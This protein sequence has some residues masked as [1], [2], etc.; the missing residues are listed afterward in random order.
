MKKVGLVSL[1]CAKNLI[2]SEMILG[3]LD[4]NKYILTN[5]PKEADYI[6]IN[7]CAFIE[8]SKKETIET[9][10]EMLTYQNA[11]IIV[12]GCMAQR[13]KEILQKEIPEISLFITLDD[14]PVFNEKLSELDDELHSKEG[15]DFRNRLLSTKPFT[16]YLRIADGCNNCCSYCAIPLIRGNLKSREMDEIILEAKDLAFKGVKE[17]V[18]IAQDTTRY[19]DDL[20]SGANIEKLLK[21][22][23]KIEDFAY[24]RLLYLYP[25][26]ITDELIELI[27]SEKKLTPYFDIPIQHSEN[28]VLRNMNRR[29]DKKFLLE[30]FGKIKARVPN[31]ILRTTIMVG[32]PGESETDFANLLEFVKEVEF[33]HLGAFTYS[34]EEDTAAHSFSNQIEEGVKKE[35]IDK[36]MKLQKK[37]SYHKNKAHIGEIMEGIIISKKGNQYLFRSYWNSP[38]EVD[39]NIYV[40][41][42]IALEEGQI[43]KVLITNAFV[44]DLAGEYVIDNEKQIKDN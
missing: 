31:A 7:T 22:L 17:L 33:D 29:G 18:I 14:Y 34:K 11:K 12:V 28:E 25:D 43:V 2:D 21:S 30:L 8:P 37:I 24:I 27:G 38:D 5:D 19:G 44:Y 4:K 23:L 3:L 39:G 9:I 15:L 1:G 36:L 40:N 32:F 35:R 10:F 6:I 13:Y 41:S 16:A 20:K 42:D 26:E